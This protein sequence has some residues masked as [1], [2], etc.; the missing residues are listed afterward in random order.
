MKK[1]EAELI[2]IKQANQLLE[3]NVQELEY[4]LERAKAKIATLEKNHSHDKEDHL[5]TVAE[6]EKVI[7]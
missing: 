2:K 6:Y 1:K 7:K 3:T 4:E 5:S